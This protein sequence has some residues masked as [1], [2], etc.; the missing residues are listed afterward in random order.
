MSFFEFVLASENEA[1]YNKLTSFDL[2]SSMPKSLHEKCLNL[3][4]D[5][6]L[7][8]GMP[9]VVREWVDSGKDFKAC[10]KIQHDLL[11]TY[12]DDFH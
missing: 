2:E 12:R 9:E 5:F 6:C 1:L 4:H 8:G 10:L 11:T 7:A 3:Y